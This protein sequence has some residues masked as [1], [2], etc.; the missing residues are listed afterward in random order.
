[1]PSPGSAESFFARARAMAAEGL[2]DYAIDLYLDGLKIDPGNIDVHKELREVSLRRKAAGGRDLGIVQKIALRK[3]QSD[4]VSDMINRE[5]LMSYDPENAQWFA[6]VARAAHEAGLQATE[7]YFGELVRT[8][9][10]ASR[11]RT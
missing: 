11:K 8:A 4:P 1:M 6:E 5:K 10:E 7:M 2:L 9:L 3:P